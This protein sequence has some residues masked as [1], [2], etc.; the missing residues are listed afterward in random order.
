MTVRKVF[1]VIAMLALSACVATQRPNLSAESLTELRLTGVDVAF[2]DN[3]KLE[4]PDEPQ[5]LAQGAASEQTARSSTPTDRER[6]AQLIK[7]VFLREVGPRL[8]GVRPVTARIVVSLFKPVGLYSESLGIE[9]SVAL[10]D[11]K[12][13]ETL[14]LHPRIVALTGN[15]NVAGA[16]SSQIY[17]AQHGHAPPVRSSVVG[18]GIAGGIAVGIAAGLVAAAASASQAKTE[19]PPQYS[20]PEKLILEFCAKYSAWLFSRDT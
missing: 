15:P 7:A 10:V 9:A 11:P 18:G 1:S 16:S 6:A 5:Q 8:R 17:I 4:F 13:N 14:A 20:G 3:A 2:S 12:N 19:Q